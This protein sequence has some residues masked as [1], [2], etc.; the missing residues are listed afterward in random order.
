MSRKRKP[1]PI[2]EGVNICDVAAEGNAIAKVDGMVVFVPFAAPGDIADIRLRKKKK[3]YAEGTISRLIQ[4][5]AIRV[6]PICEHFTIC[7]GCRWQHLPYDFQLKC[8]Q[9]Q[10]EDALQ[11]IAK[12]EL[13]EISQILGSSQTEA[14][15]NKMEY[16][17]SNKCWLTEEQ[18]ASGEEF[19]DRDAAGFHIPGAFDKVLDIRKCMLQDDFSNRLRL[20][21]KQYGKE[22]GYPLYDLR[23]QN[24]LLRTRMVR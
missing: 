14:Y 8:K 19:P 23:A 24:G 17:F 6:A 15:R 3:S 22:H 5:G 1:L 13:P 10:V 18:L 2:L 12:V 4:P 20:Y 21:I 16:T 11:R 9:Q 7:G